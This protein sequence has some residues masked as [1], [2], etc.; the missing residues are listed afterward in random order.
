[1]GEGERQPIDEVKFPSK[2]ELEKK[3][4]ELIQQ[5]KAAEEFKKKD[6]IQKADEVD[7]NYGKIEKDQDLLEAVNNT[8][9]YFEDQEKANLLDEQGRAKL[10]ELRATKEKIITHQTTLNQ[11][12]S[13]IA[14]QPEIMDEIQERANKENVKHKEAEILENA[15]EEYFGKIEVF[16]RRIN[17]LAENLRSNWQRGHDISTE[18][19]RLR[20]ELLKIADGSDEKFRHELRSAAKLADDKPAAEALAALEEKRSHSHFGRRK[21]YDLL[22][23][24]RDI[25][26]KMINLDSGWPSYEEKQKSLDAEEVSLPEE[27]LNLLKEADEKIQTKLKEIKSDVDFI[28]TLQ[29][30]LSNLIEKKAV[31]NYKSQFS[32][33]AAEKKPD[34]LQRMGR[35]EMSKVPIND[36]MLNILKNIE[37]PATDY[38]YNHD[39]RS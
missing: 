17:N 34:E 23:S 29:Y 20:G 39:R 3:A 36:T 12:A 31:E 6:I 24:G 22:L 7:S 38:R 26:E 13:V 8:L 35:Y 1:M 10:E 2:E 15:H 21:A 19:N 14:S 11:K 16:A 32:R 18:K 5:A 37:K 27:F 4:D 30:R 28:S 9:K 33:Q 25:F